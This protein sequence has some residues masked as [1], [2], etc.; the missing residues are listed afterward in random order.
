MEL[1]MRDLAMQAAGVLAIL[2]AVV[3]GVL[4]ETK[5]FA[6]ARIEP[7]WALR[8]IRAVWHCGVVAW[9]AG[10]V[11][12]LALPSLPAGPARGWIVATLIAVY[13]SGVIGNA[14]ATRGRHFGWLVLAAVV[15]LAAIGI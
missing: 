9:I 15:V 3:H 10:G 2:A 12:L 4:G 1:T 11:L 14:W 5:V 13:G 8:L 6:V 7:A